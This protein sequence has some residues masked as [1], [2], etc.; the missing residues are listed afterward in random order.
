MSLLTK[1]SSLH[2]DD[3]SFRQQAACMSSSEFLRRFQS[4][5]GRDSRRTKNQ[6][7]YFSS[8]L[9]C[10]DTFHGVIVCT[11]QRRHSNIWSSH[12]LGRG[13]NTRTKRLVREKHIYF[14]G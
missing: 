8:C 12:S 13:R 3:A 1:K 6:A 11:G 10:R 7:R 2:R 4:A 14:R 5:Y 9:L